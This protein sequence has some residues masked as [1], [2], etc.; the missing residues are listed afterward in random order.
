MD[1]RILGWLEVHD[2]GRD[3][4][5]GGE[6]PRAFLAILLLHRNEVVSADRL[7]DE[8]WGD[9]PPAS[10]VRTLEAYVS[11]LRK[12]LHGN[13]AASGPARNVLTQGHGY[14]LRV[15][16]GELDLDRFSELADRGRQA[17]AAGEAAEAAN[18]LAEAL[19][20]WRGPPLADF[21]YKPFAQAAIAQLE[22]RRRG[23]RGGARGCRPSA[24]TVTRPGGGA[25]RTH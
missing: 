17:L 4:E 25:P 6:K 11:R 14:T 13:G 5:L 23:R 21:A 2:D 22:E 9:S 3:V 19:G 10:A 12:A 20:L 8:L 18:L 7:I 16:P 1:Y 24:R 15:G